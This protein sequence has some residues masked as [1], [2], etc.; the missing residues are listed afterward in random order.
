MQ[1]A[2]SE[3]IYTHKHISAV[4]EAQPLALFLL[5]ISDC[6]YVVHAYDIIIKREDKSCLLFIEYIRTI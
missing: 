3:W 5:L 6:G 1:M 4:K 2:A